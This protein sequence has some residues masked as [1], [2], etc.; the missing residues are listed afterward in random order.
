M[1]IKTSR[2]LITFITAFFFQY[3]AAQPGCIGF[4]ADFEFEKDSL[5]TCTIK[6]T[7]TSLWTDSTTVF[8]WNYGDGNQAV[9]KEEN[10]TYTNRGN[11][12]VCLY[13]HNIKGDGDTTCRDSVCKEVVNI[14]PT[15]SVKNMYETDGI[16][17][18]PNPA[19]D[20]LYIDIDN[21]INTKLILSDI[22]GRVLLHTDFAHTAAIDIVHLANGIYFIELRQNGQP[23]LYKKI[24]RQ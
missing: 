3:A 23:V 19:A 5:N 20:V 16:K 15:L 22:S 2:L 1:K 24:V 10:Y 18:Y 13:A 11:F 8:R 9:I 21:G 6:F 4:N 7:N 12:T 14:C 17:I